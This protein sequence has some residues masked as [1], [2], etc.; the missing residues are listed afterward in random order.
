ML[1]CN[2]AE[3]LDATHASDIHA[4][5]PDEDHH[6]VAQSLGSAMNLSV[7]AWG[8]IMNTARFSQSQIS[9][10][11]VSNPSASSTGDSVQPVAQAA[12]SLPLATPVSPDMTKA[13]PS[14]VT[15]HSGW[16]SVG[17]GQ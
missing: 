1:K 2:S 13:N 12:S 9:V 14:A 4:Y 16:I 5:G 3:L 6:D 11:V 7:R 10:P 8:V 17:E 15:G